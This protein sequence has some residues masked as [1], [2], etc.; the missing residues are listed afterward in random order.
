VGATGS[1]RLLPH[2][3]LARQEPSSALREAKSTSDLRSE[4]QRATKSATLRSITRWWRNQPLSL[5]WGR[6]LG[7]VLPASQLP[8]CDVL[9]LDCEGAEV[10]ILR[11][12]TIQPRVILVET[13][14]VF[15]A[16]TNLAA[17]VLEK[18]G[19]VVSDR[20]LAEPRLAALTAADQRQPRNYLRQTGSALSHNDTFHDNESGRRSALLGSVP[21][22]RLP[23]ESTLGL[24]ALVPARRRHRVLTGSLDLRCGEYEGSG[25]ERRSFY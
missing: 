3:S 13:H 20:G 24:L 19:Y 14:G 9:Q 21:S 22:V 6:P 25:G 5:A 12:M 18:R 16:P 15:G 10:G 1:P 2:Y 7:P 11:E 8:S 23:R 4:Q 17:S